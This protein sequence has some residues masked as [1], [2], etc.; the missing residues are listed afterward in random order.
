MR[1]N[2]FLLVAVILAGAACGNGALRLAPADGGTGD[3][4]TMGGSTSTGGTTGA[5]GTTSGGETGRSVYGP[6][7]SGLAAT[8]GPSKND[9]CCTSLLV[10]GGTYNRS[11]DPAAPATVS[12]F[13]LDK[14]EVTVGRFRAFVSAGMGTQANPPADGTGDHPLIPGTGWDST[15]NSSLTANAAALQAALQ[16]DPNYQTWT[17]T[18]GANEDLP[19]NCIDWYEAFALCAWDGGRLATEAE[20]GYAAAG[21]SEQRVYPWGST[22]PGANANLA[23]WDCRY[24][25]TGNCSGTTNIAPVGSVPAGNGK[26][27]QSDLAGN[28]WEW[29]FDWHSPSY[30]VPCSDCADITES[31][32]RLARGG[33]FSCQSTTVLGVAYRT[34]HAPNRRLNF[35]GVRCARTKR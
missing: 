25:G 29:I 27:G 23:V 19:I 20:W 26:W 1:T 31:P 2:G 34:N 15:W 7:C 30:A 3:A 24:H 28:I 14:Y 32:G 33:C 10:P 11:N 12:D 35:F 6:S 16:C 9:N 4:T 17:S 22:D 5:G 8:C 18:P 13:Y 21:G